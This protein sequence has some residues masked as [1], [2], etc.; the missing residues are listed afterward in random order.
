M[1]KNL[2]A[3]DIRSMHLSPPPKGRG[4]KQVGYT[5]MIMLDG[6]VVKLVNNNDD[7]IVDPWEITNGVAGK[8][9]ICRH[10]VYV[11]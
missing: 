11:G 5:D 9:S 4:W 2:T 7:D 10:I 3:E 8:N 6:L 1:G